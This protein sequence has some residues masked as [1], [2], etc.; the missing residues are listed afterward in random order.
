MANRTVEL[1]QNSNNSA[2]QSCQEVAYRETYNYINGLEA[3]RKFVSPHMYRRIN[4]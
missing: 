2:G 3:G 1:P 4:K